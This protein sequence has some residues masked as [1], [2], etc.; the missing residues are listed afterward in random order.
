MVGGRA[1]R[2]R[3]RG[4]KGVVVVVVVVVV[5]MAVIVIDGDGIAN[6]GLRC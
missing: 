4:W 5:V 1:W 2:S 6:P 3:D